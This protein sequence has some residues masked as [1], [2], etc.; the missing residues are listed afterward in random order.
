M[1]LCNLFLAVIL[2]VCAVEEV[3]DDGARKYPGRVVP[4]AQV[5]I[6][7][8]VSGEILEVAFANGQTVRKGDLLYRLDPV[9]YEAAVKNAEA[10]T[11]ELKANLSYAELSARRHKALVASRAVSQDALDNAVSQRDA[12]RATLAAAEAALVSARDDLR[13]CRILAPISGRLGTTAF[14][15][16]NYV[17]KGGGKLVTLIQTAPIRVCFPMANGDY[18]DRFGSRADRLAKEGVVA[19]R[20]MSG[21]ECVA[22]GHVEYVENASDALTDTT[23]VYALF[24]NGDG[25]LKSGQTVMVTLLSAGGVRRVAVPPN[26]VVQDMKGAFVWL[27]DE[28]GL[29]SK[30]YIE[31]GRLAGRM[32][33]VLEG[34]AK[35]DRIVADGTHKVRPGMKVE[36][37]GPSAEGAGAR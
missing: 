28:Q 17:Q 13:H 10:K 16:G 20:L 6:V 15:E 36:P 1:V 11:V 21:R 14:T 9:K 34:L 27:L 5:A 25:L 12:A 26:A 18:Q 37:E 33:F 31:R 7:P 19:L 30:R 2:P 35:G 23:E 8:Q 4:V 32:Q 29:A 24:P 22:T 3:S